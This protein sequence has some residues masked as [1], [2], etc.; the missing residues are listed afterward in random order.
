MPFKTKSAGKNNEHR[1]YLWPEKKTEEKYN[2]IAPEDKVIIVGFA[3]MHRQNC[4]SS[5]FC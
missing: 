1:D 5:H 4:L 3:E 2:F